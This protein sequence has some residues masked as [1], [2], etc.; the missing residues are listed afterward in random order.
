MEG[1][2]EKSKARQSHVC[3]LA[4]VPSGMALLEEVCQ[5]GFEVSKD[6]PR[7]QYALCI[8]FVHRDV[9]SDAAESKMPAC[10]LPF[11]TPVDIHYRVLVTCDQKHQR[12]VPLL[13]LY[14]NMR[15]SLA[16]FFVVGFETVPH[17]LAQAVF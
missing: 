5:W 14:S 13:P 3:E 12:S 2:G 4:R 16:H 11:I 17:S 9:N 8:L 7:S 6:W 10:P 15:L 1:T